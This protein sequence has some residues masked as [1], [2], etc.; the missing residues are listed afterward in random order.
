LYSGVRLSQL[1][2]GEPLLNVNW[3]YKELKEELET[4][5]YPVD[6]AE[7]LEEFDQK[8]MVLV[9]RLLAKEEA[10]ELEAVEAENQTTEELESRENDYD[11]DED[12]DEEEEEDT[13]P[14]KEYRT[15]HSTGH[16]FQYSIYP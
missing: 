10:A 4:N 11:E 14:L 8:H 7:I 5:M 3:E 15:F 9:F 12:E 16:L 1:A 2:V 6:L 13:K